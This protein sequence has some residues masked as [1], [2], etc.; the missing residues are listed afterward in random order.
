MSDVAMTRA[1]HGIINL[2]ARLILRPHARRV[3][4]GTRGSIMQ[5][6]MSTTESAIAEIVGGLL[7]TTAPVELAPDASLI[8]AG[9]RSIDMVN[10]L[11]QIEGHFNVTVPARAVNPANFHS[12][13]SIAKLIERIQAE[14]AVS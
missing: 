4:T 1:R 14:A 8:G 7:P 9:L 12:V 10:L 2:L 3:F 11:L 6:S 5:S 13:A